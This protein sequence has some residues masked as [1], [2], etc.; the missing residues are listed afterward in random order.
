M[1]NELNSLAL[2]AQRALR[3][4]RVQQIAERDGIT[5]LQAHY[6]LRAKEIM[7]RNAR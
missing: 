5:D 1:N 4:K 6:K 3:D 2:H 7:E